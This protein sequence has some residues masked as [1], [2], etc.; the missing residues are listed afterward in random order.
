MGMPIPPNSL[1]MKG[2]MGPFSYIDMGGMFSVLKVR[3]NPERADPD[4]WYVHPAGTVAMRADESKMSAD[5]ISP[6]PR[7]VTP[8]PSAPH[9]HSDHK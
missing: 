9:D 3:D 7:P 4:G 2:G 5:G 1:P 8:A 6:P